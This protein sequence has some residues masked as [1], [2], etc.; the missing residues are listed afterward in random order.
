MKNWYALHVRSCS[1]RIVAAALDR[2]GVE[3]YFPTST[4]ARSGEVR[5]TYLAFG[6]TPRSRI[7][8]ISER[9]RRPLFPGYVFGRFDADQQRRLIVSIPQ[10]VSIL[11]GTIE[12]SELQS[13]RVMAAAPV[14]VA[15]HP[16]LAS[17]ERV[18]VRYGLLVGAEGFVVRVKRSMRLAC[19]LTLL[20]RSISAEVDPDQLEL[21][22]PHPAMLASSH[23][24]KA[25]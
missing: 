12:D 14:S 21:L 20:G 10:V 22:P 3:N 5:S 17:G 13:V 9:R 18:R 16:F 2:E 1:E 25:A 7:V 19:S 6:P 24:K 15:E 23:G 4:S 11:G 8:R